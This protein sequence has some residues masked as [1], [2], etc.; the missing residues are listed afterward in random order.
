VILGAAAVVHPIPIHGTAV[1]FEW[2]VVLIVSALCLVLIRD[3]AIDRFEGAFLV[4]GLAAFVSLSVWLARREVK[5]TEATNFE[6]E[7]QSRTPV[8][9]RNA[10]IAI[11]LVAGG[12]FALIVGG[13]LLVDGAVALARIAGMTERV[14][15]LTIVAAGTSAPELAAS[16]VAARR[17]HAEIA[18][19]NL[20]GSNVFNILGILGVTA[21]VSPIVVS[22]DIIRSDGWWM[23]G[24]A[25]VLFPL[26]RV[27]RNITRIEGMGMLAG[28]AAYVVLLLR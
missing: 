16:I 18:V 17:G 26:M 25:V 7:V 24:T 22:P 21:V 15:G 23:M 12:V 6:S 27:G 2:P 14:I 8:R 9:W 5:G 19:A 1:K 13:R 4:A 28:Y 20:L 11:L 3:G 10:G